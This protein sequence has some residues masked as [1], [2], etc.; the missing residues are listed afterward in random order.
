M[1]ESFSGVIQGSLTCLKMNPALCVH[2]DVDV[3]WGNSEVCGANREVIAFRRS[4]VGV[5]RNGGRC[6]HVVI[7]VGGGLA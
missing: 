1:I 4:R 2:G 5:T 6:S 3:T 7:V